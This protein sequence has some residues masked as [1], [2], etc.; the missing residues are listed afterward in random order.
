MKRKKISFT[1]VGG[2]SIITIFAVLC[3][4]VFALLSLSTS[5]ADSTLA[6]KSVDAVEKYYQADTKAEEILAQLR[7]GII[8]DGVFSEGN[9]Y[10]YQCPIDEKQQISVEVEVDGS[11]YSIKKWKK[12]YIGEWKADETIN[13]WGGMEEITE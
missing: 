11:S 4:I 10:S 12:E 9:F 7:Q 3:F 2:S 5:K 1:S 6:K 13:V 8:P